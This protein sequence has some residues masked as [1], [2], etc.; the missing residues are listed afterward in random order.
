LTKVIL[1]KNFSI[2]D[3]KESI[4]DKAYFEVKFSD[5]DYTRTTEEIE[6]E[7]YELGANISGTIVDMQTANMLCIVHDALNSKM[8]EKFERMLKTFQNFDKLV[9]FGW[10]QVK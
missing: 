10:R 8:Q 1:S 6:K 7:S 9:T 3:L 4:N 2:D 5:L